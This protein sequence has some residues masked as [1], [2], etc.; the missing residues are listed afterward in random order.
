MIQASAAT[1]MGDIDKGRIFRIAPPGAKYL[2]PKLDISTVEGAIAALKNP[3]HEARYLAWT[4][5]HQFGDRRTRAGENVPRRS[6]HHGSVPAPC[7]S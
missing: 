3:N 1:R 2:I 7:G 6:E 5:L 4:A